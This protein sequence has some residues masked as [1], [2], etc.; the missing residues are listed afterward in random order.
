MAIFT[1]SF[2]DTDNTNYQ[3]VI[4]AANAP[5]AIIIANNAIIENV[6]DGDKQEWENN[7]ES[8][9]EEDITQVEG[10]KDELILFIS[11][12]K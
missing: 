7:S 1:I 4:R 8:V 3:M 11:H 9:T 6:Y 12:K 2:D 10:T 5:K